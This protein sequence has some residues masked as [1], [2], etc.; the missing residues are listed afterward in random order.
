[1]KARKYTRNGITTETK[2][3]LF[4]F[5]R[6]CSAQKTYTY[7]LEGPLTRPSTGNVSITSIGPDETVPL[8]A[9]GIDTI[10]NET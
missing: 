4:V 10:H 3:R 7:L 2:T 8:P 9:D 1:M 6:D 5:V